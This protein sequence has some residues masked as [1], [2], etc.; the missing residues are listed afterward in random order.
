MEQ[1]KAIVGR[2]AIYYFLDNFGNLARVYLDEINFFLMFEFIQTGNFNSVFVMGVK[3][4]RFPNFSFLL[5][6]SQFSYLLVITSTQLL[7]LV[8]QDINC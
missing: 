2:G 8:K 6:I 1:K 3:F 7:M 4:L 5:I